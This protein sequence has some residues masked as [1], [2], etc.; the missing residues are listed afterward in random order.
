ILLI[1]NNIE[2]LREQFF[3]EELY[4]CI[5]LSYLIQEW[6]RFSVTLLRSYTFTSLL[7]E[8][9]IRITISMLI[10]VV[11]V[12]GVIYYYFSVRLGYTPN[13]EELTVFLSIYGMISILYLTLYFG[14]HLLFKVNKSL[15]KEEEEIEQELHQDFLTYT[16]D[17]NPQLLFDGLESIILSIRRKSLDAVDDTIDLLSYLYRYILARRDKELISFSEEYQAVKKLV[18][19]YNLIPHRR[20]ELNHQSEESTMVIPSSIVAI[21]EG[22][23]RSA[24]PS[25][26]QSIEI[27]IIERK[28]SI[29]LTVKFIERLQGYKV[30]DNE[31][32]MS[33]YKIFTDQKWIY[34]KEG[35]TV[36]IIIPAINCVT[37]PSPIITS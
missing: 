37:V 23:I 20:V 26:E 3:G 7:M 27:N 31:Y 14:N 18:A 13:V 5:V 25:G 17:I 10:S 2:Q 34:E 19:L 1:N 15:L 33:R 12:W 11:I 30:E 4:L 28:E 8:V 21:I 22:L 29:E 35:S 24:I 36:K 6:N 16:R 32:W 9:I